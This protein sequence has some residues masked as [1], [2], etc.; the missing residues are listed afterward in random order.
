MMFQMMV[1]KISLEILEP[2]LN[3]L[4]TMRT[5]NFWSYEFLSS[6][7]KRNF[8]NEMIMFVLLHFLLWC[9]TLAIIVTLTTT[10]ITYPKFVFDEN[11][12][13]V[14]RNIFNICFYMLVMF[15]YLSGN[16]VECYYV[17]FVLNNYFQLR[18]VMIFVRRALAQ[19]PVKQDNVRKILKRTIQ[20]LQAVKL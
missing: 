4:F 7:E 17:Y 19:K 16:A 15:G 2:T 3:K 1:S 12:S 9:F 6:K 13:S 5:Q 18:M 20:Q 14:N 8:S 10:H 11:W